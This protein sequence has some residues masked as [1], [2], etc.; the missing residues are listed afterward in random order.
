MSLYNSPCGATSIHAA[1]ALSVMLFP[2]R[3]VRRRAGVCIK[4]LLTC[5]TASSVWG[6]DVPYGTVVDG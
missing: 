5:C 6:P 4:Y 1:E 3:D 2:P